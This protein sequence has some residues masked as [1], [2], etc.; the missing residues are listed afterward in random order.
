MLDLYM[1]IKK[2]RESL[3]MSQTKLAELS[4]YADKTMISKIENGNIDLAQ[5][6]IVAI[7]NA[8]KTTPRA[9]MGWDDILPDYS[10]VRPVTTRRFPVLGAVACGEPILMNEERSVQVDVISRQLGHED[11]ALTRQV[12]FH[13][14]EKLKERDAAIIKKAKML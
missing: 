7:A 2:R 11:S 6:K 4:G 9:L 3:G 5:S 12:Y 13:R 10:N 8:L 14:T 1:N